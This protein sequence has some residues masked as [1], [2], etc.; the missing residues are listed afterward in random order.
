MWS[1]TSVVGVKWYLDLLMYDAGSFANIA[2]ART[3]ALSNESWVT[4][5]PTSFLSLNDI[6]I[7][8]ILFTVKLN[9]SFY[10][11]KFIF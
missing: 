4:G 6:S 2:G 7:T 8:F 5:V 11:G 10:L 9:D 3:F 1:I